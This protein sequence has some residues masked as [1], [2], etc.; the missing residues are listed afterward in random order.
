MAGDVCQETNDERRGGDDLGVTGLVLATVAAV[1]F[2]T[3]TFIQHMTAQALEMPT[4]HH[5][6]ERGLVRLLLSLV[7]KPRWLL[8]QVL[9]GG[10]TATQFSALAFAPVAVVEPIVG[11]GLVVA[12]VLEAVHQRHRPGPRLAAGL[13]LCLGGLVTFL[14][15]ARASAPRHD[16]G[17]F[18]AA[19]LLILGG[20][21]ALVARFVPGGRTGSVVAGLAAGGC[22]GVAVVAVAVPISRFQALGVAETLTDWSPYVAVTVGLLATAA[23]Q[24]AYVRGELAWS[25]PALTVADPLT[26]TILSVVLLREQLDAATAPI[27]AGGAVAAA[28]GVALSGASRAGGRVTEAEQAPLE[29]SGRTA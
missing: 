26:A 19:A 8:G 3:G 15:F 4:G 7:R 12:I 25:L 18:S 27:W 28:L 11:A 14:L 24:Q 13:V 23:T 29:R 20:A 9:A 6:T 22:L 21:L 1:A 10:G 17:L 5:R 16:P 2:G